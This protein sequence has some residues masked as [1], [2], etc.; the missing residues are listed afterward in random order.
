MCNDMKVVDA[1][2]DVFRLRLEEENLLSGIGET[3]SRGF[4]SSTKLGLDR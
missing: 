4:V 1:G 2:N 3:T